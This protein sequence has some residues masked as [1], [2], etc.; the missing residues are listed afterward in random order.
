MAFDPTQTITNLQ[1]ALEAATLKPSPNY[2]INGQTVN[3]ADYIKMLVD[4]LDQL[5]DD[6]AAAAAAEGPWTIKKRGII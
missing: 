6:P 5:T 3:Y 1:A 2:S 4:A